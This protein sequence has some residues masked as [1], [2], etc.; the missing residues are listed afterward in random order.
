MEYQQDLNDFNMRPKYIEKLPI[1]LQK[2]RD[3]QKLCSAV[4]IP[5]RFH[6]EYL[7]MPYDGKKEDTLIETDE[8]EIDN[9]DEDEDQ[10]VT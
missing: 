6:R 3:L 8:E 7:E 5:K 4:T 1:S 10:I 2:Y 9:K